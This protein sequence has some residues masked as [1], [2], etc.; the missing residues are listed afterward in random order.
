MKH[1]CERDVEKHLVERVESLGGEVRKVKWIGRNG[2]PDRYVML[3][4]GTAFWAELKKPGKVAEPHQEREHNRMRRM[5]QKVFVL[6][7]FAAVDCV[8]RA[9]FGTEMGEI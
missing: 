6:D 2:A 9:W 8:L 7:C 3:P 4:N 5:G 1:I